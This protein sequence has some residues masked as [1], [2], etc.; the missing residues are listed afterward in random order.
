MTPGNG[1]WRPPPGLIAAIVGAAILNLAF[2]LWWLADRN[3]SSA[4][5]GLLALVAA[6]DHGFFDHPGQ[7]EAGLVTIDLTA[8]TALYAALLVSWLRGWGASLAL[9][10]ATG[11]VQCYA[12]VITLWC[13]ALDGMPNLD[14]TVAAV[15]LL[16]ALAGTWFAVH[17]LL[18]VQAGRRLA[19]LGTLRGDA[20]LKTADR[21]VLVLTIFFVLAAFLVELPWLLA[22]TRLPRLGGWFGAMWAFYGRADRGYFDLVSGFE[23][24]IE[25][26]HIFVTQWLHLWLIWAILKGRAYRHLLQLAVGSYVAFSTAVY[27]AAKH[28]TGYPLMPEHTVIAFLTLYLANLPWLAG[29]A[30]IAYEGGRGL[31]GRLPRPQVVR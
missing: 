28:M 26:F 17:L 5:S 16:A 10:I 11:S 1:T 15:A 22:S 3:A 6:A 7:F 19:R 21:W 18:G 29:N 4:P 12:V 24:G 30:W 31:I 23:R 27:L 2:G 25:S 13:G 14:R 20:P 9:A 8:G